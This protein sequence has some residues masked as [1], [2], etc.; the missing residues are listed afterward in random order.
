M[1]WN[2]YRKGHI[3]ALGPQPTGQ[4]TVGVGVAAIDI[5]AAAAASGAAAAADSVLLFL[6]LLL[7]VVVA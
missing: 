6:L 7:V 5:M 3:R 4:V 1:K 2:S